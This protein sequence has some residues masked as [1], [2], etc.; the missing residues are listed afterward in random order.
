METS[1]FS[2]SLNG[3]E[4]EEDGDDAEKLWAAA[5]ALTEKR[6]RL[7]H[8]PVAAN[9]PS[10][11]TTSQDADLA[12]IHQARSIRMQRKA[13]R[14]EQLRK[15][16]EERKLALS[17]STD[18][19]LVDSQRT[20]NNKKIMGKTNSEGGVGLFWGALPQTR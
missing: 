2:E 7:S 15:R 6:P 13:E 12:R 8:P 17:K 11:V 1:D 18:S 20:L 5:L 3:L 14:Q 10:N 19:M 4:K 9:P 16:M